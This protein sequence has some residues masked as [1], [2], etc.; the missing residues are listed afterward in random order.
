MGGS[1]I[2]QDTSCKG[3]TCVNKLKGDAEPVESAGGIAGGD[4]GTN[5]TS[6]KTNAV[7]S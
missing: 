3:C 7:S 5:T 2:R 6:T 1:T 4:E